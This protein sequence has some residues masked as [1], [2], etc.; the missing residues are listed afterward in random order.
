M[1]YFYNSNSVFLFRGDYME[2]MTGAEGSC[3][4]RV[5]VIEVSF[6][7][8]LRPH[9]CSG[10]SRTGKRYVVAISHQIQNNTPILNTQFG[11]TQIREIQCLHDRSHQPRMNPAPIFV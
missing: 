9:L 1:S 8:D 4:T 2:S 10:R 7:A 6:E 3:R 5:R 11:R